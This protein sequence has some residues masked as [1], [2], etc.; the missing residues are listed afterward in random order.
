MATTQTQQTA[1]AP[2]R[3]RALLWV[4]LAAVLVVAGGIWA[5]SSHN[6][7]ASVEE[8]PASVA[9]KVQTDVVR[10]APDQLEA[11][12]VGTPEEH[13]FENLRHSLGIIDFNQDRSTRVYATHQGR[14]AQVLVKAGDDVKAGQTLYTVDVPDMTQAA[15]T[16]IS[17]AGTLRTS[18]ETLRRA[19]ALAREESIPQKELQ[20]AQSDQ[21]TAQAAYDAARQGLRLFELSD[22]DIA[23]IER[24]RRVG[25]EMAVKSPITGRVTARAAQPGLLVQPGTDPA[26]VTVSDLRTLWMVASVPESEF[27]Y[28]RVGQP[29]QVRVQAWP[30][31][32]FSGRISYLGDSMDADTRRFA[33]RA[34]VADPKREL[35]P[36]MTAD[37]QFT[38]AAPQTSVAVPAE[39]V[40][41]EGNGDDVV[42]VASDSDERGPRFTRRKV[43]RGQTADGL[44]QITTGLTT[45]DRL[46]RRKALFL[47]SLYET[48]AP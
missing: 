23:R 38:I 2:P 48:D 21:Q 15:S 37:F 28:Y 29:V 6:A 46:A 5:V 32:L 10:V 24:E 3:S 31:K 8:Q 4:A 27:S 39:A 11:L 18:N 40:V 34:E 26:P 19:E 13:Q 12:D 33:V 14:I 36:Q 30:G 16:L 35:R 25:K 42:W 1:S 22:A 7:K 47:S 17:A 44:V 9:G 43:M 45:A 20:Q 41:R